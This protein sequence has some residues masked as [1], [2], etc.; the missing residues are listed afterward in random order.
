MI[1]DTP[2]NHCQ[3]E[4]PQNMQLRERFIT[5]HSSIIKKK[6]KAQDTL[7]NIGNS[8]WNAVD[9]RKKRRRRRFKR[10]M[11]SEQLLLPT[12]TKAN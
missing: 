5:E 6:K 12:H 2:M 7:D 10:Y 8:V 11:S 9:R 1:S 3:W 4:K